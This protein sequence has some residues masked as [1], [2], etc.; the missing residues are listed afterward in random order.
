[1][2]HWPGSFNLKGLR[3]FDKFVERLFMRTSIY[4]I[5]AFDLKELRKSLER[6]YF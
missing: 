6:F 4:F 1:M 2:I 5:Y 3:E